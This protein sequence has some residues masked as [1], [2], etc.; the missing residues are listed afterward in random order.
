[1]SRGR[2]SSCGRITYGATG[3]CR[4][5]Y[6]EHVR[7]RY[8]ERNEQIVLMRA[9]LGMMTTAIANLFNLSRQRVSAIA[10]R[11]A[12]RARGAEAQGRSAGCAVT[13]TVSMPIDMA[14]RLSMLARKMGVSRSELIRR[15]ANSLFEKEVEG[16][17]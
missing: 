11:A 4:A 8:R 15:L 3:L 13:V 14:V 2:C 10:S 12:R 6:L 9:D 7:A 17:F 1:M 5:C 16:W